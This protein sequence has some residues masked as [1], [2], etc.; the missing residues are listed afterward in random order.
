MAVFKFHE[1]W[2]SLQNAKIIKTETRSHFCTIRLC[3]R[4]VK[5]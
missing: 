1:L 5:R 4:Y 3:N 2:Y